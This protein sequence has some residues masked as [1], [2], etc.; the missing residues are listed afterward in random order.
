MMKK[1]DEKAYKVFLLLEN[2][3]EEDLNKSYKH[4]EYEIHYYIKTLLNKFRRN[5][6]DLI[7]NEENSS[8]IIETTYV[9][10]EIVSVKHIKDDKDDENGEN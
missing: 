5:Y 1:E 3:L 7:V 8:D 9:D 6:K 2:A 10:N 4:H